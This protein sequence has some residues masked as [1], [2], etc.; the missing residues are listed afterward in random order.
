MKY[1]W[2]TDI[3]LVQ[4]KEHGQVSKG[5]GSVVKHIERLRKVK[6]KFFSGINKVCV[7]TLEELS[8]VLSLRKISEF[9][10][11]IKTG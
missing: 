10:K 11:D 3:R 9:C 5:L 4:D 7:Q 1:V 6:I 8:Q 2:N